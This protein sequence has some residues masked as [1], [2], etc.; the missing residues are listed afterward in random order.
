MKLES[1][2]LFKNWNIVFFVLLG[3]MALLYGYHDIFFMRP[4]SIHQWRQCD[5]LSITY[6]YYKEGMHFFSP[7]VHWCGP[8]G[9]GKTCTSE[10]PWLYYLIA[11]LWQI[12]GYHE[13][14]YR[15]VDTLIAFMGLYFLFKLC[16]ELL[17]DGFW[18]III[19]LFLFTSPI[20]VFY[21]NN[22]I[23][24]V[25]SLSITLIAWYYFFKFYKEGSNRYF[26]KWMFFCLLAGL[27]KITALLS[28]VP[29]FLVFPIEAFGIYRFKSNGKIFN[30]TLTV[31]ISFLAVIGILLAWT[32]YAI[33]YND[34]HNGGVFS[35]Q[36][37]PLWKADSNSIQ[38]V[39]RSLFN[40]LLPEFMG[41]TVLMGV[42][43]L[44]L[45]IIIIGKQ[46]NK[47]LLYLCCTVF[48]G[49]ILYLL[50]WFQVFTVH[51]YYLTNL[52]IFIPLVLITFLDYLKKNYFA[53]FQST[54]LKTAV[55][56]VFVFNLYYCTV[57]T[58]LKYYPGS[59]FVKYSFIL[60]APTLDYWTWY[61][62]NYGNYQKPWETITP[63]LRTLGIKRE[64]KVVSI[65]DQSINISLYLM[66]QKGYTSYSIGNSDPSGSMQYFVNNGAKY[67][68]INN[69]DYVDSNWV[70]P[71][72][73]KKIGQ[74]KHILIFDMTYRM[75][76]RDTE[77]III[78]TIKSNPEWFNN[79]KKGAQQKGISIDSALLLNAQFMLKTNQFKL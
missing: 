73:L 34:L 25:P 27:T 74:Y 14:I 22:F 58:R 51:D 12:F 15:M 63:Y 3:A 61:H 53:I 71:Y 55:A 78:K 46:V 41:T 65:P 24:D 37:F 2:P 52:L 29:I 16:K 42:L 62:W 28:F 7:A 19:P 35:T 31:F 26:F 38:Q 44:F 50:L 11:C 8:T 76:Q 17:Q 68:I 32:F 20:F 72:T 77:A 39:L 33:K 10:C 43:L 70:K 1:T 13:F 5:C 59:S 30:K 79:V 48:I 54:V 23:T 40:T 6:N 56:I 75:T 36:T 45:I 64:D 49:C 66:D 67:L 4:W 57:Q 47:L 21:G 9:D 69:P 60:D 18:S